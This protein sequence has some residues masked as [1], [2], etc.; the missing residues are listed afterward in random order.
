M[1]LIDIP[2]DARKGKPPCG[3]CHLHAGETCDICGAVEPA[4]GLGAA[5]VIVCGAPCAHYFQGWR[6]L[7][8]GR[9]GESVC[10]KCGMGAMAWSLRTGI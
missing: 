6:E 4:D 7:A 2:K 3:E 10:T 5:M 1:P 9:G 8:D